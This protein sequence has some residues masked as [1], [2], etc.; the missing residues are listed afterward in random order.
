MRT[1]RRT[2]RLPSSRTTGAPSRKR[3]PCRRAARGASRRP[4]LLCAWPSRTAS[5]SL[6]PA[7]RETAARRPRR[8]PPMRHAGRP[9]RRRRAGVCMGRLLAGEGREGARGFPS[10][11]ACVCR[12]LLA[13]RDGVTEAVLIRVVSC[14]GTR[15]NNS[16]R[17]ACGGISARSGQSRLTTGSGRSSF[18]RWWQP[19]IAAVASLN[20]K[21]IRGNARLV[22]SMSDLE[23]SLAPRS[24]DERTRR[25]RQ[26]QKPPSAAT[27]HQSHARQRGATAATARCDRG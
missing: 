19:R 21:Y 2:W 3:W 10:P 25:H 5:S 13:E 15:G 14:A 18:Q 24:N 12:R 4:P 16:R 6:M 22:T 11:A 7:R 9:R 26:K 1:T 17:G 8:T 23:L 20:D 27:R